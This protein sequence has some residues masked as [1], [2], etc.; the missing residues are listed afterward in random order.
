MKEPLSTGGEAVIHREKSLVAR[1]WASK[2][3]SE[4]VEE[5]GTA[6]TDLH[7]GDT[8]WHPQ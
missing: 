2:L 6:G 3:P 5:E 7:T 1:A 8:W 4:T